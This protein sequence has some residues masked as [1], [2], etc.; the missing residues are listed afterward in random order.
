MKP[1]PL[2]VDS[3][4]KDFDAHLTAVESDLEYYR[5][6]R[7]EPRIVHFI[8]RGIVSFYELM[9]AAPSS[10]DEIRSPLPP[11]TEDHDHDHEHEEIEKRIR[12]LEDRLDEYVRMNSIISPDSGTVDV[13]IDDTR[14][15]SG[16][17]D[18]FLRF[19]KRQHGGTIEQRIA[20][21]EH[22]L[23]ENM[24]VA[25]ALKRAL[26]RDGK[27]TQHQL[28]QRIAHLASVGPWNGGRIVARAWVDPE[29]KQTLLTEGRPALRELDVPPGRSGGTLGVVENTSTVQNVVVCTLC[30][31]YPYDL[32]G[33][34]PWW[35]K[36]QTYREQ[37]VRDPR[38][39]VRE[40]FGLN[41]PDSVQIRVYDSTSDVRWMVLPER[42]AG[43]EGWNEEQLAE[44]VTRESLIGVAPALE[45]TK[46][47]S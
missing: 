10:F 45:P 34:P 39:T 36:D 29:F 26:M 23:D 33:D 18:P 22:E 17:Y 30:S 16:T 35:Y 19:T 27:L 3:H 25:E 31:C 8:R 38:G 28:D 43:T 46:A 1:V 14:V 40:M 21:L 7:L 9:Q 15:E 11:E 6:K 12:R 20:T 44:L 37:I 24:F 13:V 2:Q 42:P 4:M 5:V 47:S 41:L 32:L